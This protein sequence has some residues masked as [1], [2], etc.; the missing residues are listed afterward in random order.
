MLIAAA[1]QKHR[2]PHVLGGDPE[3][4]GRS[5]HDSQVAHKELIRDYV[6]RKHGGSTSFKEERQEAENCTFQPDLKSSKTSLK[7]LRETG[8]S[9]SGGNRGE[10]M[11]QRGSRG[12]SAVGEQSDGGVSGG[13]GASRRARSLTPDANVV[14]ANILKHG[15]GY[16]F[17]YHIL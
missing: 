3:A 9:V 10:K 15:R 7:K 13:G 1:N 12:G 17:T 6:R 14:V 4:L 2:R 5:M 16:P 11:S 8:V